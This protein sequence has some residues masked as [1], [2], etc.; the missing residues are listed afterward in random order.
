MI[1][2]AVCIFHENGKVLAEKRPED[3]ELD[4][5]NI[6]FPAGHIEENE[7]PKQAV[8]REMKEE[9]NVDV[10]DIQFFERLEYKTSGKKFDM[11]YFVCT[12]W[13]GQIEA[14][15]SIGQLRWLNLEQTTEFDFKEDIDIAK[16]VINKYTT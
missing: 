1:P 7:S 16:K 2:V 12:D 9:L 5:G 11:H 13:D 4:P 6:C 14:D 3:D 15:T 10:N 8:R